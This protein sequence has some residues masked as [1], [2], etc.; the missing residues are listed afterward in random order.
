[1]TDG[2]WFTQRQRKSSDIYVSLYNLKIERLGFYSI[3]IFCGLGLILGC[4]VKMFNGNW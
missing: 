4:A 3:L 2:K 1:M